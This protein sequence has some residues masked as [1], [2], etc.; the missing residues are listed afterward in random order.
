MGGG[1]SLLCS[2]TLTCCNPMTSSHLTPKGFPTELK[3]LKDLTVTSGWCSAVDDVQRKLKSG[4]LVL[5]KPAL[6]LS[7]AADEVLSQS[8]VDTLSDHLGSNVSAADGRK[9]SDEPMWSRE[10]ITREIGST[11]SEP[12][13]HDVLAAPSAARVDE[14]M[15]CIERWLAV[16]YPS[17]SSLFTNLKEMHL[18]ENEAKKVPTTPWS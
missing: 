5:D 1:L 6:V 16:Q 18:D 12:S 11:S 17:S 9:S 15:R 7:T 2:I 14:A 8:D 4:K 3:S 10:V 13:A